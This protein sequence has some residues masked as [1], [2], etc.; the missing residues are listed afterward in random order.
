MNHH[1]LDW[2]VIGVVI[3]AYTLLSKR[4]KTTPVSGALVFLITGFILGPSALGWLHVNVTSESLK[5][6][7]ELTLALILF[8]DAA[9]ANLS[10]LRNSA[11]LPML[12]L[13]LGL[14]L[15]ILLGF[16][17]ARWIFPELSLAEAAI[18]AV[19]LAPTDAALGQAV[20]TN[21]LVPAAIREDLSDESGLNDGIC[22]PFLL[23][24][25]A[26]AI[27]GD[28]QPSGG[29]SA[30]A[31]LVRLFIEQLGLGVLVGGVT[32]LVG[33]RLRDVC[34]RRDWIGDDWQPLLAIAMAF[35]AFSAAQ[36][37]GGSG[38]IAAF[39]A[40][41]VYGGLSRATKEEELVAA[42]SAGDV[43]SLMTWVAFGCA[44]VPLVLTRFT[45]TAL[46]YGLLSLTLVR[47]IPVAVATAGLL[48]DPWSK[49]FV[50]WFGPRGLASVVFA[51]M[52]VDAGVPH[53]RMMA[54][55][56]AVTVMLSIFA[57]GLTSVGVVRRYG[58]WMTA[59]S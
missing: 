20:V 14:P 52:V 36:Q 38:F 45:W 1:Y 22:V 46:I 35:T 39:V 7:A 10:V 5:T 47:M 41:L 21:P 29:L 24:L 19:V 13:L 32:A 59:Q 51:V 30:A 26:M 2:A 58:N 16:A 3:Y 49:L 53:G 33:T 8:T 31:L 4:L 34:R 44:V 27:G 11:R 23:A 28:N 57:H 12:L 42:E 48:K 54:I 6:L 37:L 50:G 43:L 9:K 18:L 56:V 40:G 15:T 25:L 17:V 55:T